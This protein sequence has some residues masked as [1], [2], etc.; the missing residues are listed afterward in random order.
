MFAWLAKLFPKRS[1]KDDERAL[2]EAERCVQEGLTLEKSGAYQQAESKYLEAQNFYP[3]GAGIRIHLGNLYFLQD[4]LE[5]ALHCFQQALALKPDYPGALYSLSL[6]HSR[7]D[8]L[9]EASAYLEAA[10]AADPAGQNALWF[11][12]LGSALLHMGFVSDAIDN[13]RRA[14][15]LAPNDPVV[16]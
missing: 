11:Q 16:R 14:V 10:I 12:G 8:E 6:V 1:T 2:A 15:K 3:H 9:T 13:L 4:K 5:P 7:R